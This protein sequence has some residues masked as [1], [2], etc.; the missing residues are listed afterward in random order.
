MKKAIIWILMCMVT[1]LPLQVAAAAEVEVAVHAPVSAV[2]PEAEVTFAVSVSGAANVRSMAVMPLYNKECF[3]LVEGSWLIAG[4]L[5]DFDTQKDVGVIAFASGTQVDTQVLSFTLR[6]K[7]AAAAGEQ[8]IGSTVV[9]SD[10]AGNRTELTAAAATVT[11]E[12]AKDPLPE[13]TTDSKPIEETQPVETKPVETKPVET[14]P[15]STEPDA[16]ST[17]PDP[18]VTEQ[19]EAVQQLPTEQQQEQ[20]QLNTEASP[21]VN[22]KTDD[23]NSAAWIWCGVSAAVVL[24]AA[25][26]AV[27]YKKK[28]SQ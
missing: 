21:Q 4:A 12:G 10:G 1:V 13:P 25:V 7:A 3:T 2:K 19:T 15:A 24:C 17:E 22:E 6:A 26:A 28:R 16:Q 27:L 20:V 18:S 14:Q 5:S 23:E 11:V 9:L 8:Q